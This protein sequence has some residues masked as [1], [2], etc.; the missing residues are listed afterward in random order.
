MVSTK[1]EK[2][3]LLDKFLFDEAMEDKETYQAVLSILLENEVEIL[4]KPE[5]EKELRVSPQLRQVRLDVVVMDVEKKFYYTEM[6]KRD[7]KNLIKRSR[8]YQ[9]LVDSSLLEPGSKDFNLLNDSCFIL[10]APFDIFG[11]GLYRYTSEGRCRECPDLTLEDGMIKVFINTKGRN[12]EDFSQEFL[13]LMEYIEMTTDETA[14]KVE[15]KRIKKI[16]ERIC[17]IRKSEEAG[18]KYM[19]RWEELVYAREDG[20]EEGIKE[21]IKEGELGKLIELVCKKLS[22]NKTPEMIAEELETDLDEIFPICEAAEAFAPEYD[23]RKV[24]RK[25]LLE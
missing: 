2:L 21:G 14:K 16:H 8:Y 3:N 4:E 6:Q 20:K 9:A 13:D 23:S 22:R 25:F 1:L 5:T 18:I 15:S 24:R 19:Q 7:T 11:R 10:I 17:L 12:K